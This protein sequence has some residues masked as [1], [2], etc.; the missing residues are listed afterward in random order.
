MQNNLFTSQN[1]IKIYETIF[2]SM[3]SVFLAVMLDKSPRE[4]LIPKQE[5]QDNIIKATLALLESLDINRIYYI[6]KDYFA[7][8][9]A[10]EKMNNEKIGRINLGNLNKNIYKNINEAYVIILQ[11]NS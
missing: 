10:K 5:I 11:E 6:L 1:I 8:Y 4:S 9:D 3:K 7:I 2:T